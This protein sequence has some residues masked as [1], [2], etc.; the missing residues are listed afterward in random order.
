MENSYN[1]FS[2]ED[3][4]EFAK[5]IAE[6]PVDKERNFTIGC[7]KY[8]VLEFNKALYKKLE[9][10]EEKIAKLIARDTEELEEGYYVLDKFGVHKQ[11]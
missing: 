10:S 11:G 5:K 1:S 8:G 9:F 2:L 7:N 6:T 4:T 3:L